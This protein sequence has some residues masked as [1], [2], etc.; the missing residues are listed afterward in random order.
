MSNQKDPTTGSS[1]KHGKTCTCI[2]LGAV[3]TKCVVSQCDSRLIFPVVAWG[4]GW[5]SSASWCENVSTFH[6]SRVPLDTTRWWKD[7][8]DSLAITNSNNSVPSWASDTH[9]KVPEWP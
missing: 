7:V 9:K 8:L 5:A 2:Q 4:L 3:Q 1:A 6:A